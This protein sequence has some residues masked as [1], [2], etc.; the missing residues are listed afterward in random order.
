MNI[1]HV[2]I[3]I[4]RRSCPAS[5]EAKVKRV[6]GN[7]GER[8]GEGGREKGSERGREGRRGERGREGRREGER[9]GRTVKGEGERKERER[10]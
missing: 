10:R 1:G 2:I 7:E 3:K 4:S 8:D 9:E 6:G 5:S